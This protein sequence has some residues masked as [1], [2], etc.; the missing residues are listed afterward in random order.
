MNTPVNL[1]PKITDAEKQFIQDN[2]KKMSAMQMARHLKRSINSV[3]RYI[4]SKHLD[5]FCLHPEAKR[6]QPR[7]AARRGYFDAESMGNVIC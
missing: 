5:V 7:P 2:H 1:R 4:N 6:H 3:Y